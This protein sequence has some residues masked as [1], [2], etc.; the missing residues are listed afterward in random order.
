M[1]ETAFLPVTQIVPWQSEIIDK[2][3]ELSLCHKKFGD[4]AVKHCLKL[5]Y[6]SRSSR[7]ISLIF[8]VNKSW[9]RSYLNV[10]NIQDIQFL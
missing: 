1:R 8:V 4:S 2:K 3:N 9:I 5:M 10:G 7:K 6:I